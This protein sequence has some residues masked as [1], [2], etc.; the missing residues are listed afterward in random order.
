MKINTKREN[1]DAERTLLITGIII[2]SLVLIN[3]L[4]LTF[5]SIYN[6]TVAATITLISLYS[7][8]FL[9]KAVRNS[10]G[11]GIGCSFTFFLII[12][13]TIVVFNFL[14]KEIVSAPFHW[15]FG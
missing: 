10:G 15:G 3:T 4:T 12:H 13:I 14:F 11:K 9:W 8:F 2:T 1:K 5:Y 6:G 7:F